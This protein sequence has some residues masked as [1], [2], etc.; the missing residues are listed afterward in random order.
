MG[1]G[2]GSTL[3]ATLVVETVERARDA[4]EQALAARSHAVESKL[5]SQDVRARAEHARVTSRLLAGPSPTRPLAAVQPPSRPGISQ[6]IERTKPKDLEQT[7]P[8][9]A[10]SVRTARHT[11]ARFAADAGA[12]REQV[13]AVRLAASEALTN[14]VRHAYPDVP[15]SVHITAA[16]AGGELCVLIADDGHGIHPHLH[17]GGLGLG[18]GLIASLCDELQ[19]VKRCTGGTGLWLWFKLRTQAPLLAD[20][21]RG[22]VASATAAALSRFSTTT[23]PAPE[24]N[25][26]S[27]PATS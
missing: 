21:S 3:L 12:S 16:V 22:S 17:R 4:C 24:S 19:I 9:L 15:G 5:E 26:V 1:S 14:V 11:L 25:R 20:H 18:L 2:D 8:A 7:Y 6:T 13:E 27:S 23:Q 10:E